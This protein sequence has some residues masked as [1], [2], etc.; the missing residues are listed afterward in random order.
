M[1]S[2]INAITASSLC[3]ALSACIEFTSVELYNNSAS[4]I[5]IT[6]C[7]GVAQVPAASTTNLNL[8]ACS[9]ASEIK[10]QKSDDIWIY[11]N[12]IAVP[13]I[14]QNASLRKQ[15][16]L[17]G[18]MYFAQ[19]DVD[20]AVYLVPPSTLFPINQAVA[21]TGAVKLLPDKK[22]TAVRSDNS[23]SSEA[24]RSLR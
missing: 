9:N 12:A 2:R 3:L 24:V 4:A 14:N 8:T 18:K 5:S 17:M 15:L 22:E 13:A 16:L 11:N 19:I 21:V 1:T 7:R 23:E 20:G 10:I 6:T